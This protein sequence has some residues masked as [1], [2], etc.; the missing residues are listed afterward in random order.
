MGARALAF[1]GA[2][3]AREGRPLSRSLIAGLFFAIVLLLFAVSSG[4]LWNLGINYNGVTGAIASKI[5]PAT[6][7]AFATLG[8]LILARRNP[9][10]FF[11][12]LV[13]KHPGTLVFLLATLLV[14][15]TIVLDG[16]KG[17]ATI[18]DTYLLAIIVA[19]IAAEL[20][21]RDFTRVEKLIHVLLAANAL[22][23]LA[24]Y[25]LNT[26]VFPFRF[27]GVVL[28]WD[29][30]SNGLLGHPLENAQMTGLYV[31]VLLAGGGTSMSKSVRAAAILLQLA[32]LVPFGGRTALL[33]TL[34]MTALWLVPRVL[35]LLRGARLP[36]PA[37]AAIAVLAPLLALGVGLIAI[38][39]FFDVITDRFADDGGSAKARV[40]M[41]EIFNQLSA[42][43]IFIGASSSV[44]DSLRTSRGLE[45]GI[46]NPIVRLL[47]YQGAVFTTFLIAGF[48]LF[49]IEIARRL[50][51]GY[52]MAMIFFLVI[53]NSYESIANKTLG[54]AQF[55]V[56]LLVMFPRQERT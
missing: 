8:L 27:E 51:S 49:L 48:T 34:A 29:Y 43:E 25:A 37:F 23:G 31:M 12:G 10:S 6:Y 3:A 5:H 55:V 13:T 47:L 56:L 53:I 19:L 52:A 15:G 41:F 38:G 4:L 21:T 50:R 11:V 36:L 26:K 35:Q 45:Q 14:G 28:E 24:E 44:I 54:L 1:E 46:E 33:L 40:E 39:G 18:F 9:A 20:E 2:S 32:A 30:R 22:L 7:L 17:I 16:R 42:R